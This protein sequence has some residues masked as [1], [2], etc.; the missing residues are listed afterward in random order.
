MFKSKLIA[1][2]A[3]SFLIPFSSVAK[4]QSAEL[5]H[6][7]TAPGEQGA[8]HVIS[9]ALASSNPTIDLISVSGGGGDNAMTVLQA[10]A[11]A[12]TMPFIAQIEGAHIDAWDAIGLIQ[13]LDT[14]AKRENWDQSLYPLAKQ[15]NQND[16]G[17]YVALPLTLHR[18][19]WL[20]VNEPLRKQLNIAP[21]KNWPELLAAMQTAKSA[22]I[23]P[24]SLGSDEWQVALLFENLTL[25]LHGK[26]FYQ[27]ALVQLD[28]TALNSDKMRQTLHAFRQL[29]QLVGRH[30]PHQPWN[31]ATSQLAKGEALF[32]IGG[33]W[34]LGEL[35]AADVAIPDTIN[36]YA[37]PGTEQHF[38]Y[39]MDSFI[40]F[41]INTIDKKSQAQ[42][43]EQLSSRTL[44]KQFNL[45]KGAIPVRQ[46]IDLSDFTSCQKRAAAAFTKASESGLA[47]PSMTDSMALPPVAQR[48]M[49]N[50]LF[51][52][53][54][55][56]NISEQVLIE[57]L[58]SIAQAEI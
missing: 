25:S 4:A 33:D 29:S 48:A 1:L 36:C 9:Q 42:I 12:G 50:E 39:N 28:P 6:W 43:I 56:S 3:I 41:K 40:F 57:R 17:E 22:G 38:V 24:L 30:I 19:N 2:A 47:I 5:L 34:I 46:D 7:W 58:I 18:M 21:P 15:I 45:K 11:L 27:Q 54:M 16:Q 44:Q 49:T 53:F 55:Q 32:Q 37:M 8:L 31:E 35:L 13:N 10:K 23:T 14:I 52:F 20:W 51:R 26:D